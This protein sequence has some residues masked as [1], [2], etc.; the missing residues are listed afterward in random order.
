MKVIWRNVKN[1][2]IDL[3]EGEI[4]VIAPKGTDVNTLLQRKRDWIERNMAKIRNLKERAGREIESR[5][6]RILDKYLKVF[7]DCKK[8]GIYD[9]RIYTCKKRRD[10]LRDKLKDILRE[11]LEKRVEKYS[12]R[13]GVKPN[14]IYIREQKTKWGSCSSSKNLSFNI[15]LI[16]LPEYFRNYVVAHEV[17][18]LVHLNHSEK[19]MNLLTKTGVKIPKKEETMYFWYYALACKDKI[20]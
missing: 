10:F 5:G 6:V 15:L 18:H 3:R 4:V 9:D 17:A 16:F 8:T 14:R 19:F 7:H 12:K 11:D 20:L 2:R 13:I 1:P